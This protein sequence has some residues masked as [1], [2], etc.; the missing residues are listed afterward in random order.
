MTPFEFILT[1]LQTAA[2]RA[3]SVNQPAAT[4]KQVFYLAKLIDGAG[5][6]QEAAEEYCTRTDYLLTKREASNW[7]ETYV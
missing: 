4:R 2:D 5:E 6:A 7:I 3:D 1:T